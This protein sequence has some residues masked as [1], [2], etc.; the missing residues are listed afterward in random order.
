MKFF[1]SV[2]VR[3]KLTVRVFSLKTFCLQTGVVLPQADES[4]H[5]SNQTKP[6]AKHRRHK[7]DRARGLQGYFPS[8]SEDRVLSLVQSPV[9]TG[10]IAPVFTAW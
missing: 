5:G 10:A 7:R 4:S 9:R 1:H 3:L 6:K 2:T 8:P